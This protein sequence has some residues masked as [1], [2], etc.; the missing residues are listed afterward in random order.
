MATHLIRRAYQGARSYASNPAALANLKAK[1]KEKAEATVETAG[2]IAGGALSGYLEAKYSDQDLWG[3]N[4]GL[5]GGALLTVVGMMQWAG[6]SSNIVGSV[7]E[8]MLAYE[9]GRRVGL[10]VQG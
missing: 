7:G 1:A 2:V 8:G 10:N 5:A 4:Y 3:I 9:A 6:K